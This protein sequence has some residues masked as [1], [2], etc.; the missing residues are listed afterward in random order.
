MADSGDS[1]NEVDNSESTSGESPKI[2]LSDR[3]TETYQHA[4]EDARI[5]HANQLE[6]YNDVNERAWRI[7]RLNGLVATIFVAGISGLK[8]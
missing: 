7:V 6:A 8:A 4:V 5:T 2:A 3:H 1:K